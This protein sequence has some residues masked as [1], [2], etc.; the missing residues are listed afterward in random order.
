MYL[1]T[2]RGSNRLPNALCCLSLS[3]QQVDRRGRLGQDRL[4]Q[5]A[6]K[7][8]PHPLRT[9]LVLLKCL[10]HADVVSVCLLHGAGT[11]WL[12]ETVPLMSRFSK[13]YYFSTGGTSAR[14]SEV[15]Y[16]YV[17]IGYLAIALDL[18]GGFQYP[19]VRIEILY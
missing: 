5:F 2:R 19:S 1:L 11:K 6:G 12:V 18:T 14:I 13:Q 10:F 9:L 8:S 4:F 17:C 16:F 15:N 3:V 7:K